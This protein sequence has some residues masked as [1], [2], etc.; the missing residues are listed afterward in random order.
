MLASHWSWQTEIVE[1]VKKNAE[2]TLGKFFGTANKSQRK[3]R[4]HEFCK[5]VQPTLVGARESVSE[6][7]LVLL[8]FED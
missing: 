1:W 6:L 5:Q 8:D 4:V 3:K 7:C 2:S